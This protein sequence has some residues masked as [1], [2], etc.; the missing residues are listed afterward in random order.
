M[1]RTPIHIAILAA[2]ALPAVAQAQQ[3]EAKTLDTMIVTGTRVADRTVAES[4]S[5]IDV[6]TPEVL[7]ATAEGGT[8]ATIAARLFLSE[9]TVRNHISAA[10]GKLGVANRAEAVRTASE[11]G[12]I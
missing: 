9:G 1:R 10:I 7:Q 8:T 3:S 12:W 2:L 11:N 4:Q 6:I 5:P